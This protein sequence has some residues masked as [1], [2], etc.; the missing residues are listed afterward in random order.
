MLSVCRLGIF[1]SELTR[2]AASMNQIGMFDDSTPANPSVPLLALHRGR[3]LDNLD[4]ADEEGRVPALNG[5]EKLK[6]TLIH[7]ARIE[8]WKV[9][10]V[11]E[12]DIERQGPI[13]RS[14][15]VLRCLRQLLKGMVLIILFGFAIM[16][17]YSSWVK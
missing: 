13:N 10:R 3:N 2:F 8:P 16:T 12:E 14:S 4:L 6:G 9:L 17:C 1:N 11:A 5:S 15:S 7:R